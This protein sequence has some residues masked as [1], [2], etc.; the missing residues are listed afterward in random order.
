MFIRTQNR[1]VAGIV[2]ESS[3]KILSFLLF[4]LFFFFFQVFMASSFFSFLP[5][6][7]WSFSCSHSFS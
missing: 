7:F 5:H 6:I 2:S 3:I 1:G 4:G